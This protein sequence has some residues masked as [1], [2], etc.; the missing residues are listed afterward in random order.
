MCTIFIRVYA[1]ASCQV[2][3]LPSYVLKFH[4]RGKAWCGATCASNAIR[5]LPVCTYMYMY[6][7]MYD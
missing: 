2:L 4:A 3:P 7:Y 1:L 5:V 6:M